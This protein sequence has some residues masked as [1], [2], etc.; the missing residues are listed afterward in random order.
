MYHGLELHL[1]R[2]AG[3]CM[4]EQGTYG[5]SQGDQ[6]EWVLSGVNMINFVTIHGSALYQEHLLIDC[7][8]TW[9]SYLELELLTE[10]EW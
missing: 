8:L 6:L 9:A 4:I 2:V 7:I 10:K 3:K 1:I 5:L